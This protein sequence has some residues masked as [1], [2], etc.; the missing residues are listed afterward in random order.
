MYGRV[1]TC[2]D[3]YITPGNRKWVSPSVSSEDG[4]EYNIRMD[5]KEMEGVD[6][7]WIQLA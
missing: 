2:I 1:G 4:A 6:M 5:L 7:D 3:L